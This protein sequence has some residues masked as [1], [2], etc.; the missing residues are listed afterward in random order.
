MAVR[1]LLCLCFAGLAAAQTQY[2][3]VL[4]KRGPSQCT[5]AQ[6][7]NVN[8]DNCREDR[9]GFYLKE[10]GCDNG[11]I[12]TDCVYGNGTNP[13]LC[14]CEN[15][16]YAVP[17]KYNE[18]CSMGIECMEG[19]GVCYRPCGTYL[20]VTTC[21]KD[22]CQWDTSKLTCVSRSKVMPTIYWTD[23]TQGE[24]PQVQGTEVVA[25]TEPASAY[26][27]MNYAAF[28]ASAA[29][30]R[31]Q[32]RLVQNITTP[33]HLFLNLDVNVDGELSSEEFKKLPQI[34]GELDAAVNQL[35]VMEEHAARE[36][37]LLAA[38]RRLTENRGNGRANDGSNP[39]EQ[40]SPEVCNA[41]S[42][43]QHYCS[44]DVSCKVDCAECGW[45]S[46]HDKA[47]AE[48][49]PP[50]P[51]VCYA[52]G[53]QV[54]CQS[55]QRCHPPGDCSNCVDRTVVDHAQH[56]C[57]ALWWDPE[58]LPTW[59]NWVCRYRNKIGMPCV[60]DQDC[61]HGMR[62]CLNGACMPFQPY[63]ANQTCVDDYD[64]PH[65]GFYCPSDPTGGQNPYWVQYCRAQRDEGMTCSEDRECKPD[66]RCNTGEALA[67]CRR[68]FSLD[69]GDP[70]AA[71]FFCMFGWRD[72]DGKC[73]PPAK[74]KEAGRSCDSDRDCITTDETG[75]RGTCTCKA[76][77]D[78]DDSK[79]CKPVAG[80]FYRHQEKLRDYLWFRA[81]KCGSF[82][83]EQEC[84]RIWGDDALKLKLAVECEI[85]ELS[86]GPYLPPE[87]CG[88][89]DNERFGDP[90]KMLQ[91]LR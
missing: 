31:V 49:V 46:A 14:E 32:E 82:W 5:R 7:L 79:Y 75:R 83:T 56:T 44:F 23:T 6:C 21:N 91:E 24:T 18:P 51:D 45:K 58:P 1:P 84:L 60:A 3:E 66:M 33:E 26:F 53:Q 4:E 36:A 35:R 25:N 63:N 72:R 71:D 8:S 30:Y 62:R 42:P 37:A 61:I 57:L 40:A 17:A 15:P 65:L 54:Y 81:D 39:R 74:S 90:C 89:K 67:R 12:C 68:L 59:T 38:G 80:D 55:D 76:W 86:G 11:Q 29:G 2:F 28:R 52:D 73:A 48:C 50:S 10:K 34:L 13:T 47:F 27:P 64:C 22:Y 20:H 77:W 88:I 69:I 87:S 9:T 43:R 85:Q 16:P 41:Q 78:K 19:E 70:A